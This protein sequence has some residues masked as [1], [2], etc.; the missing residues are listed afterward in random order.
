LR[1]GHFAAARQSNTA[2]HKDVERIL[3]DSGAELETDIPAR[4]DRLRWSSFHTRVVVALGITWILDGL[5]VTLAGAVAGAV[6]DS[7]HLTDSLIGLSASAYLAGAVCGALLFGWLAD[8]YGRRPLFF[9]TLGVYLTATALTGLSW[10]FAAFAVFRFFTG[11]GIGG[12]YSAINSAIQ[13]L[14]PARYRGRT[15]LLI[16]GS[17]WL[18]AALGSAGVLVLLDPALLP[19]WLGW[20]LA[21]GIGAALGGV[22]LLL[23]RSL[24][25]SP[26]WLM[27]N[28]RLEEAESIVRDIERRAGPPA[29]AE[30]PRRLRLRRRDETRG[31]MELARVLFRLYPRRAAVC[32]LLMAAQAFFYNAI[33]F[34]YALVLQRFYGV[35]SERI[36]MYML[37]FAV[38]NFLGPLLLGRWFDTLGRRRM[39]ALSY[40]LSALLLLL[41]AALFLAG[42]FDAAGQTMAWTV[43][44]FFASAAA[45]AA[46]LTA[47]ESFPLEVRAMAISVFYVLGTAIGGIAGPALFGALVGS[48]ERGAVAAGYGLGAALML[49]GGVVA[50]FYAVAAEGRALEQ[51]AEPLSGAGP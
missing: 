13:E 27:V 3:A 14:T 45:S 7:L 37:P 16:N 38:G 1:S 17:F 21:F 10:N 46:Y 48:G 19:Q 35:G 44:F 23:R 8:R 11:A 49:A 34:T 26:R 15:D 5:E 6:K 9:V 33:F 20:R 32:L 41:S 42:A 2:Y 40:C 18:G 29:T 39:L 30:A 25:E 50:W 24:P 47:G 4:L 36:G 22:I 28:G 31:M 43:V 51:V 12:E